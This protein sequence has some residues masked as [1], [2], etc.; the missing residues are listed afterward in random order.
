[1]TVFLCIL[2]ISIYVPFVITIS[3]QQS[4][5]GAIDQRDTRL[6]WKE[7]GGPGAKRQSL[8]IPGGPLEWKEG[9][10]GGEEGRW[11]GGEEEGNP[12]LS[13]R[14]RGEEDC[15][16]DSPLKALAIVVATLIC[17]RAPALL[18]TTHLPFISTRVS[19]ASLGR[20]TGALG[21]KGRLGC[22]WVGMR[23]GGLSDTR[24]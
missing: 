21:K 23:L 4:S 15:P 1:M 22:G 11:G 20:G 5:H 17:L 13:R 2:S 3:T 16:V 6:K 7:V 18:R 19:V 12:A 14:R 24:P 8:P 9:G 10:G